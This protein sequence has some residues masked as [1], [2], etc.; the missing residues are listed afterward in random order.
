M[1]NQIK[2]NMILD[3]LDRR[4]RFCRAYHLDS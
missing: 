4:A 2:S 3:H 1:A